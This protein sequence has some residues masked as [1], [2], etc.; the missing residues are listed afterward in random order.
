MYVYVCAHVFWWVWHEALKNTLFLAVLVFCSQSLRTAHFVLLAL[1]HTWHL[2]CPSDKFIIIFCSLLF[3]L[4][5]L[6]PHSCS[7]GQVNCSLCV[8]VVCYDWI[9]RHITL[10][11]SCSTGRLHWLIFHNICSLNITQVLM[12]SGGLNVQ[13]EMQLLPSCCQITKKIKKQMKSYNINK[14]QHS[15]I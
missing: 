8:Y 12:F 2:H 7:P 13:W 6:F 4:L 3:S 15:N 5:L 14:S 1:F 10:L 9:Y 11:R